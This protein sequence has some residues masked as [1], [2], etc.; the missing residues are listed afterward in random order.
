MVVVLPQQ[1]LLGLRSPCTRPAFWSSLMTASRIGKSVENPFP[2]EPDPLE[3]IP[4]QLVELASVSR[5]GAATGTPILYA[6]SWVSNTNWIKSRSTSPSFQTFRK[7]CWKCLSH[8]PLP[9]ERILTVVPGSQAPGRFARA[10]PWHLVLPPPPRL[11]PPPHRQQLGPEARMI[12]LP[13]D[14][15]TVLRGRPVE[16][17]DAVIT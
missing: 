11:S 2:H 10:D 8:P 5:K 12:P 3:C 17:A 4:V 16:H 15:S 14:L 9:G 7:A 1:R 13:P 6:C